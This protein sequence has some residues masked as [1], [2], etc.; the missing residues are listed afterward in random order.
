[1]ILDAEEVVQSDKLISPKIK[2][3]RSHWHMNSVRVITKTFEKN[4]ELLYANR[5]L[6]KVS[7]NICFFN[8]S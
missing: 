7:S 5:I 2:P 3:Q 4:L 8:A 6:S 1:M